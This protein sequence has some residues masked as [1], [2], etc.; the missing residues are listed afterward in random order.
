MIAQNLY[1]V[2][3]LA[4]A[5]TEFGFLSQSPDLSN[6]FNCFRLTVLLSLSVL[7]FACTIHAI[8]PKETKIMAY[9]IL[10]CVV[11]C[12]GLIIYQLPAYMEA[13]WD[14]S[15]LVWIN[16]NWNWPRYFCVSLYAYSPSANT[17]E[18][19]KHLDGASARDLTKLSIYTS[20]SVAA[21]YI[22]YAIFGYLA[23]L[24]ETPTVFLSRPSLTADPDVGIQIARIAVI[25]LLNFS[26]V[27]IFVGLRRSFEH[28]L[29]HSYNI[30]ITKKVIILVNLGLMALMTIP[31]I[32]TNQILDVI[33]II[34]GF[35][36]NLLSWI[37]PCLVYL[38]LTQGQRFNPVKAGYS[39][40][41]AFL[42]YLVIFNIID[43][44]PKSA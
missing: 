15:Q 42:L 19:K 1:I 16:F 28:T 7:Q 12:L 17:L 44:L 31:A 26:N 27:L 39:A 3:L 13:K 2:E 6:P 8:T 32:F 40:L 38:K 34:G 10:G 24:D 33:S 11:Y 43:A 18:A 21:L 35:G 22:P 14:S 5:L 30:E 29:E 4:S 37:L 9:A 36:N 23:L 20:L 25:I 41:L